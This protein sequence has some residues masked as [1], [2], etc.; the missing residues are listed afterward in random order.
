MR[1]NEMNSQYQLR[2]SG[3]LLAKVLAFIETKAD[4]TI[5]K[6]REIPCLERSK[7]T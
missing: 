5:L 6:A 2:G 3:T 7:C 1:F 4:S